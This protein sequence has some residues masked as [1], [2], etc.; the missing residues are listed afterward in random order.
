MTTV[1]NEQT[2]SSVLGR[3][4]S[5][6]KIKESDPSA[7]SGIYEVEIQGETIELFCEMKSS[8]GGWAVFHN[9]M[10]GSKDFWLGLKNIN[11]LTSVGSLDLRIEMSSFDGR[12][13]YAEYKN[14]TVSDASDNYTMSF[15]ENSFSGNVGIDAL[16]YHNNMQFSTYDVDNDEYSANCATRYDGNGGNWFNACLRQNMNGKYGGDGDEGS[17]Y[18]SWY[19]FDTSDY[20]MALKTMR[21][22]VREVV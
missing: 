20:Y 18:M 1:S 17:D 9:R 4:N 22:M 15:N 10:D 14:F 6:K 21:W 16:E 12:N 11:K 2:T 5:C 3:R 7:I 13:K 8:G 19:K